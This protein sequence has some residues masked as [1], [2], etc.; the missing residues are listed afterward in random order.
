MLSQTR[1]FV[2]VTI[3]FTHL[4]PDIQT[5]SIHT[6]LGILC[7]SQKLFHQFFRNLFGGLLPRWWL[8]DCSG[9]FFVKSGLLGDDSILVDVSAGLFSGHNGYQDNSRFSCEF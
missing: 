4:A 5:N 6:E 9:E 3:L 8:I 1:L 7:V 2:A